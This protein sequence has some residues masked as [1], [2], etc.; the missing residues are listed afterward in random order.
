MPRSRSSSPWSTPTGEGTSSRPWRFVPRPGATFHG[1][2]PLTAEDVC[3]SFGR[4]RTPSRGSPPRRRDAG[5]R[6]P[7]RGPPPVGTRHDGPWYARRREGAGG[8]V[9]ARTAA[10]RGPRGRRH[11]AASDHP[12]RDTPRA[13]RR[14]RRDGRPGDRR[15]LP[16]ATRPRRPARPRRG[17]QPARASAAR[18][19]GL[20]G[21]AMTDAGALAADLEA[22]RAGALPGVVLVAAPL[23]GRTTVA[24]S[25]GRDPSGDP[26]LA[27][28]ALGWEPDVGIGG[29]FAVT[30]PTGLALVLALAAKALPGA[31]AKRD[32]PAVLAKAGRYR[33]V[34]ALADRQRWLVLADL[35]AVERGGS[36]LSLP[37]ASLDVVAKALAMAERR[38]AASGAVTVFDGV[39]H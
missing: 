30:D 38:L 15:Y 6:G 33:A 20:A 5:G 3:F 29:P 31:E 26:R 8:T 1:G 35:E 22:L 27:L 23:S 13:R 18:R 25:V 2:E 24:V 17:R 36:L 12:R 11:H 4:A 16:A 9:R 34:L 10:G 37:A 19:H 7:T 39:A 28:H 21:A 32:R 14:C